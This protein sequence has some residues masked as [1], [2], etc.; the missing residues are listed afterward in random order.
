M[1]LRKGE[2]GTVIV[3]L[4]G[5]AGFESDNLHFSAQRVAFHLGGKN[6][7]MILSGDARFVNDDKGSQLSADK[8]TNNEDGLVLLEGK[9][10]LR[11]KTP[12]GKTERISADRLEWDLAADTIKAD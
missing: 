2:E 9:A 7:Q 8:I 11:R 1:T 4:V 10:R 3:E 12:T 5:D 6:P